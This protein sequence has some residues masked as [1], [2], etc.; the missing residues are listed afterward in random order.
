MENKEI[1]SK[2]AINK[3]ITVISLLIL[4]AAIIYIDDNTH[5]IYKNEIENVSNSKKIIEKTM[6]I[7]NDTIKN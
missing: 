3:L 7:N 1:R 6:S 5:E 4:T 2:K